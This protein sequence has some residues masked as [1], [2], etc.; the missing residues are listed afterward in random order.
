MLKTIVPSFLCSLAMLL[1][2]GRVSAQLVTNNYIYIGNQGGSPGTNWSGTGVTAYWK[3]NN[4]GTAVQPFAGTATGTTTNYNIF[5]LSS[6]GVALGAGTATTLIRNPYT[7]TYYNINTFPGD[8]LVVGTN[9]QVRFKHGGSAGNSLVTGVVYNQSTNNFPGN[10]GQPGLVLNGGCLNVGDS[11]YAFVIMGTMYSV[12]GTVSYLDPA[13]SFASDAGGNGG[14][15]MRALVINSQLSGSGTV[16]LLNGVTNNLASVPTPIQGLSNTFTGTWVVRAGCLRGQGDGTGD[17]YNSLGTNVACQYIINPLWPVPNTFA[18]GAT[19]IPGPAVLDMGASLANCGGSLVL[20]NGGQIYL[21]GNVIF[22]SVTIEGYALTNATYT[23]ATLANWFTT[24]NGYSNNFAPAGFPTGS[25]TLTVQPYGNAVFAPLMTL[26]PV[27]EILYPGKTAVF[28]AAANGTTPLYYQWRKSGTVLNNG[29]TGSGS[30]VS[31]AT[32]TNL[33]ISNV[34]LTDNANYTLL[35]SNVINTVVSAAGTLTVVTPVET[36]ETAVSN[37]NPVAFY[38]FNESANPLSGTAEAFDFVGGFNGTYGTNVQNGFNGIAGPTAA[39]GFPGFTSTNLAANFTANAPANRVS[40][41]AWNLN[42]NSVTL[43][44]WINPSG[45][46]LNAAGLIYCRGAD[47]VAGLCYDGV[48]NPVTGNYDLGYNWNNDQTV[49]GWDSGLS[50]PVGQWSFVALVVTPNAATIYLMNTNGLTSST[51]IYPHVSQPFSSADTTLIGDD[52]LDGGNGSRSF[53]GMMDDV[54]VFNA[55]LTGAQVANLFYTA[56]GVSSYAPVIGVQPQ[57]TNAYSGQ[58]ITLSVGAGGS[59]PL[60]FQWVSATTGSGGPY[61]PLANGVGANGEIVSGAQS[62][63]LTIQNIALADALDY[64]VIVTN[65]A[66]SGSVTSIVATV[67]VT[68]SGAAQNITLTTQEAA[69]LD[70]NSAGVWSDGNPASVS[71]VSE[72][73]STYELLQGSRLR[74]PNNLLQTT[75]PGN[76]LSLDGTGVFFNNPSATAGTNQGE[77]R[78]KQ[79]VSPTGPAIVTFPL[80]IMN[81]GQIDSGNPGAVD[82]QGQIN[83]V[84]NA[85]FYVDNGGGAGRPYQIDAYITGANNIEFHDFDASLTGGLDITCPTN[86]YTGTWNIVQGPLLGA[87]AN[88][89]GTNSIT[90]GATASLETLYDIHSPNANLIL[91]GVMFLHQNDTFGSLILGSSALSAGTYNAAQ[92]C[93]S[94]PKYFPSNWVGHYGSMTQTNATGS[95]TVLTSLGATVLQ[96]PTPAA[97]SLYPTQT[98]QFTALGGGN[99]PLYY[100]WQLNGVGLSDNGNY[101]GSLSN[102]LTV[103]NIILANAGNYTVVI[104]NSLGSVTSAPAILTLLPTFPPIQPIAIGTFEPQGDDWNTAG[105][106]NDGQGGLPAS[107]SALE[108]PGSTYEV[109]AGALLRTPTAAV[110]YTN[111]PGV[112]LQIDG[113]GVWIN[114][115]AAG[116]AQ[117]ELR[118]KEALNQEIVYF[119]LL[120]MNGGQIDNGSTLAV[121]IQGTMDVVS[122]TPIYVDTSGAAGRIYQIDAGL[123]GNGSIEYHDFDASMLGGLDITCP[124]NTYTGTWNI[125]QGPLVGA[126]ANSL[127]TNSIT[128]GGKAALETLY[129]IHSPSATLT[130]NGIFYLHQNDTFYQMSV[131]GTG[132]PAGVYSYAQLAAAYPTNFPAA[133]TPVY[134]SVYSSA[135]G[136]ITVLN[137]LITT[138]IITAQPPAIAEEFVGA[139]MVYSVTTGGNLPNYQW[140]LNGSAVTGATNAVYSFVSLAGTN[141]YYCVATNIAGTATSMVV[142]NIAMTS[143]PILTF[144]DTAN[145]MLQGTGITPSLGGDVL[146]LT[147]NTG[148]EAATAFYDIAQYIEGFNATFTYTPGGSLAA[149]GVTFCVQNSAN[150]PLALGGGGGNLGYFGIDHSA[151][152]EFNIYAL[153]IGGVG[154][155]F[156]TNGTIANPYM[157]VAPVGLAGGNPINV[158]LNYLQGHMKVSLTDSVSSATFVTNFTIADYTAVLGDTVGYVGFTGADGGSVS[159]QQVSNFNFVPVAAPVLAISVAGNSATLNWSSGVATNLVL[160][161]SSSLTGPWANVSGTPALVGGQYQMVV[162]PTISKQFFRLSSP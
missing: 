68:A 49:Y 28:T 16:A 34:S 152:V 128:I 148:N 109:Q 67:T 56:T 18:S 136:S 82:F 79:G 87:G 44:G 50:V 25:G 86:T 63:T 20:T 26:Q 15:E 8:S 6:N 140:F 52:S 22:Q 81:G 76:Q 47:T 10:F 116:S 105:V 74:T 100:H 27:S 93:S 33:T 2:A 23:Y 48:I 98:A 41:P 150:G 57:P 55:A 144:D 39:T 157:G 133:W 61:T 54:A 135:S 59:A 153:A 70:W 156:G 89:L 118:F 112:S 162:T 32:S 137:S 115:P 85:I 66:F 91:S 124:T 108:Y 65:T 7:A 78:T 139:H 96:N 12:P 146:T 110:T 141:T 58:T 113:D 107:T 36:Y 138:P 71:A 53:A 123:I 160:Q 69:G 130:L 120:I 134:G 158:T 13:D 4:A 30:V 151:A 14:G 122:N 97:V 29:A 21:H 131:N 101:V 125:V 111:F 84:S 24:A 31:G 102:M 145:W 117:G 9:T 95:I 94:Y 143:S 142:T 37:L 42:T 106:W 73:G 38:Q 155:G 149:D 119:P 90:I 132:V 88:S 62:T 154:F 19:F 114:S 17:G 121:V 60:G 126:G 103:A 159:S 161:Q 83:V 80:L 104:S 45:T 51:H 72:P 99:P 3:L 129:D 75:F 46:Q 43:C 147:D 64:E 5:T 127:G 40:L 77:L 11:G 35:I 92:L 1:S